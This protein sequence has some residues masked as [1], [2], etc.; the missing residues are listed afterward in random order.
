MQEVRNILHIDMDAFYASIEQRDHPELRNKPIAVGGASGRGVVA[1]ASYEARKF[2]IHSAMPSAIASRK[3][4]ELVFIKPRFDVYRMVSNK[5]REIFLTHTPWVEP[6]SLDEAYLDVTEQVSGMEEASQLAQVIRSE[7][8]EAT[9]LNASAGISFNKF[10]AKMASDQQKPNGQYTITYPM[11]RKFMDELPI[12]KFHGI[13][14]ATAEKMKKLG[15]FFGKDLLQYDDYVLI[16]HFGKAGL[17]YYN[18]IRGDDNRPVNPDRIRKSIGVERT[19][20]DNVINDKQLLDSLYQITELLKERIEKHRKS[21]K[22]LTVKL[23]YSDFS[24]ITRSKT[25]SQS[26]DIPAIEYYAQELLLENRQQNRP[27]RL[28][29]LTISNLDNDNTQNQLKLNI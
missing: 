27:I 13:G 25:L 6:L 4:P 3:C 26:F 17:Y 9:Q 20:R 19:F 23:R 21:G 7:I 14:Q 5:I 2:G 22:T 12:E 15:I 8:K 28:L 1:A 24:T 16:R 11:A 29:G 18:I 10:L